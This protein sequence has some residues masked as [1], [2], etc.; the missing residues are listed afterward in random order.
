M[1]S[2]KKQDDIAHKLL[3]STLDILTKSIN[4]ANMILKNQERLVTRLCN[5]FQILEHRVNLLERHIE[6]IRR[7]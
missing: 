4:D 1:V 5:D 7:T 3:M 6:D 2:K